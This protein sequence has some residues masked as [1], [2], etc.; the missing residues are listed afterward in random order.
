MFSTKHIT[1]FRSP[2]VNDSVTKLSRLREQLQID[3]E[4]AW[5]KFLRDF[6]EHQVVHGQAVHL[7]ATLDCLLSLSKVAQQPGYCRPVIDSSDR[8]LCIRKGRNPI[9]EALL[10]GQGQYVPND[11]NLM[12][13]GMNCVV[14]S[15][16]NM[17]GKSSYMR[18]VALICIMAQLGSYVPAE[19]AH[20]T[21]LDA[22]HTRMGALDNIYEQ[23]STFMT[24]LLETSEILHNATSQSLVIL[25]E[26]GRGTSTHDGTAIAYATLKHLVENAHC[27]ILF[28]S[29]YPSVLELEQLHPSSVANFHMGFIQ[30]NE[31]EES[32]NDVTFLYQLEKGSSKRSFG[33]HV[34]KMAG[35]PREIVRQAAFISSQMEQ[36]C[37]FQEQRKCNE[38]VTVFQ[39]IGS[40][41]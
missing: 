31:K 13:G 6:A 10:E 3:C 35:V 4:K 7:L 40:S 11:T 24:E 34:A 5:I 37:N 14:I 9:S 2:F 38:F 20:L 23:R 25:D 41:L 18:Q 29:H 16:P 27:Y 33:L 1:R 17:G 30:S 28:V 19:S 22:V 15:G 8:H 36:T 12:A 32:D 21:I 26:L 39:S